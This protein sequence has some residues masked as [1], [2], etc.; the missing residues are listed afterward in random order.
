MLVNYD[1][2]TT[3]ELVEEQNK[4]WEVLEQNLSEKNLQNVR[5][6]VELENQWTKREEH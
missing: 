6:L 5:D 2:M 3:D 1:E 4:I